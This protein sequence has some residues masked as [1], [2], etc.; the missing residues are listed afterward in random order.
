[1][2]HAFVTKVAPSPEFTPSPRTDEQEQEEG[3][4]AGTHL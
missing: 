4:V 1:M 3:P 2:M